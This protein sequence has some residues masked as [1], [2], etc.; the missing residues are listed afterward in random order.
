MVS[1]LGFPASLCPVGLATCS[2]LPPGG[3]TLQWSPLRGETALKLGPSQAGSGVGG[4][5]IAWGRSTWGCVCMRLLCLA[6]GGI[7]SPGCVRV[8]AQAC[9]SW[10]GHAVHG[11]GAVSRGE[12]DTDPGTGEHSLCGVSH[13]R[14][15]CSQEHPLTQT[16]VSPPRILTSCSRSCGLP[17]L[18]MQ[19]LASCSAA[20]VARAEP[21]PP[22][23]WPCSPSGTSEYV[24]HL[25]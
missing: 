9:W 19:A 5:R 6:E 25:V 1:K 23:W 24:R 16:L 2:L 11:G 14:S 10:G 4:P 7:R 18:R 17:L 12:P 20:S 8:S 3:C 13:L 15:L 22:W 21:R